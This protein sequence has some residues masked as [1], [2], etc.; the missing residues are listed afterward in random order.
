M[1]SIQH[2]SQQ[3]DEIEK[4]LRARVAELEKERDELL[5]IIHRDGGHYIQK[6]GATKAYIDATDLLHQW[7]FLPEQLAAMTQQ[8][9]HEKMNT[10]VWRRDAEGKLADRTAAYHELAAAEKDA[11]RYDWFRIHTPVI[12]FDSK[13]KTI[14]FSNIS[15]KD[16]DWSGDQL[17]AAID[18]AMEAEEGK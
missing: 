9:S 13:E 17:D 4:A 1:T 6:H 16:W 14:R 8:V 10:E 7:K 2:N 18:A 11:A 5:C 15:L 3:A 12:I